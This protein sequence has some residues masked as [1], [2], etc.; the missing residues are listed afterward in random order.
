MR[1]EYVEAVLAVVELVPAGTALAYGDVAELLGSGGPRQ[2]GRVMSHY[3]GS[4]PWWRILKSSGHGPDGHEAEALRRYLLEG[5]PL[6]ACLLGGNAV[7]FAGL[8]RDLNARICKPFMFFDHIPLV[9]HHR[10]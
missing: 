9:V 1:I 10:H 2:I 5:T 6:P 8:G 4:V 3:G 7:D